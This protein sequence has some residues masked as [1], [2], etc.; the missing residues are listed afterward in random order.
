L[1][2]VPGEESAAGKDGGDVKEQGSVV[3]GLIN[4]E[5]RGRVGIPRIRQ[6]SLKL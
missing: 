2:D 3:T 1:G 5:L 4:R 6:H